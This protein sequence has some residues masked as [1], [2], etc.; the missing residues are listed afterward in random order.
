MRL[1]FSLF[2]LLLAA[3]TYLSIPAQAARVSDVADAM[4]EGD[5]FDAHIELEYDLRQHTATITREN[6]QQ[7]LEN[8]INRIMRVKE[9][10]Y[11]STHH[12]ITPRLEIGLFRDLAIYLK[13]P[14][15]LSWNQSSI[16]ADG[17]TAA[18]STLAKDK[19]SSELV[20]VDGWPDSNFGIPENHGYTDWRFDTANGA[21]SAERG[22]PN[23]PTFGLRWSPTNNERR[24]SSVTTTIDLSYT[25]PFFPYMNPWEEAATGAD[26]G[27]IANGAHLVSL[28]VIMS[29]RI[30]ALDPY[31]LMHYAGPIPASDAMWGYW[32]QHHGGFR[33]G[34]EIVGFEDESYH[35]KFA[36][37]L[38]GGAEYFSEGRNYS[39]ISDLFNDL[40]YVEQFMRTSA[41][42][43]MYFRAGPFV[44]FDLDFAFTYDTDHMVTAE[45]IGTDKNNNGYVDLDD[46]SSNETNHW[47]NPVL[48]TPGRRLFV[49]ESV[50]WEL[51]VHGGL[52]F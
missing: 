37:D 6:Y 3:T 43:G 41:G 17:T 5:P 30:M 1:S 50:G 14:I 38:F 51:M 47:Y 8:D 15:V 42:I 34:M 32:G 49:E 48:D 16:Y 7:D 4:D 28:S 23:N 52:T 44:H 20:L 39:E 10:A 21:F 45:D 27:N 31:F 29:R 46:L 24:A 9:L 22:G 25:P 33:T 13:I 26:V 19:N 2:G 36:V 11:K 35:Q 12:L 18:N 40:T